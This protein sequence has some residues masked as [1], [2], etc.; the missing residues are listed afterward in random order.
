[1]KHAREAEASLSPGGGSGGDP[2]PFLSATVG[3]GVKAN[4]LKM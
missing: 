3:F 1:M 2:N 4:I